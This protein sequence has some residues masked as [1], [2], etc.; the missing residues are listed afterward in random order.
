MRRPS[1]LALIVL[2]SALGCAQCWRLVQT[3]MRADVGRRKVL[4][5]AGVSCLALLTG[6]AAPSLALVKGNAPP[7]TKR[8]PPPG[9]GRS[10]TTSIDDAMAEG[11]KRADEMEGAI[12]DKYAGPLQVT[13]DGDRYRDVTIGTGSDVARG[14]EVDLRYRVMK[15]G[16]RSRDGISGE[17]QAVFSLGYGEDDDKEGSV[18][19]AVIGEGSLIEA[20]DSGMVGMKTG[21]RRRVLV[22]PQ[23]GWKNMLRQECS[24]DGAGGGGRIDVGTAVGI[25]A[26]S[27]A[28]AEDCL[29]LRRLP[30]PGNYGARRRLARRFD[31]ALI[32]E[33]EVV[34]VK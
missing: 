26:V 33:V 29:D 22:A 30:T 23:R 1:C 32:V 24:Y 13:K 10:K 15:L 18:L 6:E 28:E 20:L 4:V 31:E 21:G 17:A 3:Q 27:V 12:D 9:A 7:P 5:G 11:E 34:N 19:T 8:K 25:P 2:V 16:K 14:K